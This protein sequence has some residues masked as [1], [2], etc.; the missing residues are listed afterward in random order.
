VTSSQS[1]AGPVEGKSAGIG[2]PLL[3][4][5]QR[6]DQPVHRTD[7]FDALLEDFRSRYA[8]GS[9]ASLSPADRIRVRLG[10]APA[11]P[12]A[13]L[14]AVVVGVGI[15]LG[16]VLAATALVGQWSDNPWGTWVVI[17][18][19]YGLTY[20]FSTFMFPPPE[21]PAPPWLKREAEEWTALLPLMERESDLRDLDDFMDRMERRTWLEVGVG[22][23]VAAAMLSAAWLVA[24]TAMTELPAGSIV[25]LAVLLFDFGS[26]NIY[27]GTIGNWVFIARQARYDYLLFWPSPADTPE[28]QT[29]IRKTNTQ[30]F[31]TSTWFTIF[32]VLTIFLVSW[33]SP[34]VLPLGAG[35]IV[36]GYLTQ[37]AAALR[38]RANIHK[39]VQRARERSLH[40]LRSRID[41]F[42]SRYTHLSH[43]ETEQLQDLLF[44]HDKIRDAPT[45]P[46][47]TRT[48][49]RT[50]GGLMI[51]TILFLV[52]VLG[53]V[54]TERF[55]D[56]ILP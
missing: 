44:L 48:V 12:A 40:G 36:I 8:T 37:F 3:A 51:P 45:T 32:L 55:F 6:L 26:M 21:V 39:I 50:A 46:T 54:Y 47:K 41:E 30:G 28:V 7:S 49:M 24:P 15:R 9:P 42:R 35:F 11:S 20:S 53:E 16:L 56:T 23:T 38:N 19:F 43:D 52:T 4:P 22:L 10:V 33:D 18:A 29:A 31:I 13:A 1:S 5:V 34:L 17:F 14:I 27:G 25:L 2:D